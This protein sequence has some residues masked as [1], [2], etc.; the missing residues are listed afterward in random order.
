MAGSLVQGIGGHNPLEPARQSCPFVSGPHVE[1]WTSIYA[2]LAE[3]DGYQVAADA[4]ALMQIWREA[5]DQP[6]AG[7]AM[8]VRAADVAA[9]GAQALDT[10]LDR[11][12]YLAE[13]T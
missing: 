13:P 11:L 7:R 6:E 8:A 10:A 2:A 5:L 9:R 3:V 4:M 1:N 12:A